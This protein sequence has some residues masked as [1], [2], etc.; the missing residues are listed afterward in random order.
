MSL[1]ACYCVY[2]GPPFNTYVPPQENHIDHEYKD[3]LRA[4]RCARHRPRPAGRPPPPRT[5]EGA[6]HARPQAAP[7]SRRRRRPRWRRRWR[8]PMRATP[9]SRGTGEAAP[10]SHSAPR[11]HISRTMVV[12]HLFRRRGRWRRSGAPTRAQSRPWRCQWRD[13]RHLRASSPRSSYN[14]THRRCPPCGGRRWTNERPTVRPVHAGGI[15]RPR[16]PTSQAT[17]RLS[18]TGRL[19]ER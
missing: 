7:H 2:F 15:L 13:S 10:Q 9:R 14:G 8:G 17:G 6:R 18:P 19:S 16:P 4:A 11:A 3:G 12:T 1:A 5:Q